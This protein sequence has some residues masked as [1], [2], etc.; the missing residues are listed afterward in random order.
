MVSSAARLRATPP[1]LSYRPFIFVPSFAPAPNVLVGSGCLFEQF[2]ACLPL[3][4][5]CLQEIMGVLE[6]SVNFGGEFAILGANLGVKRGHFG[7]PSADV[8]RAYHTS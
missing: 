2:F 6:H 3:S 5:A 4:V 1:S 8:A 7:A